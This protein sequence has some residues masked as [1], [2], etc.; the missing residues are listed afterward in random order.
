MFFTPRNS[1]P[2][3]IGIEFFWSLY[4]I[5][6]S[7]FSFSLLLV[8]YFKW[9]FWGLK[10]CYLPHLLT[11]AYGEFL[12]CVLHKFG[13]WFIVGG[14]L[15]EELLQLEESYVPPD[16]VSLCFC[17]REIRVI[18]PDL[19][20]INPYEGKPVLMNYQRRPFFFFF[21]FFTQS[22]LGDSFLTIFPRLSVDCV[23]TI[24]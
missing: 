3:V 11:L 20:L 1:I 6:L 19:I 13:L 5:I 8:V 24:L 9:V 21:L 16:N 12:P 4:L 17:L 2:I 15:T 7:I 23:Y 22:P 14:Q 18:V 10:F